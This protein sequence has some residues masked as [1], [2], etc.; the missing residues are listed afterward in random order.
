MKKILYIFLG[1]ILMVAGTV[2]AVTVFNSNQVGSSPVNGYILQTNGTVST[3]VPNVGNFAFPFTVFPNYSATTTVIGF[4]GLFST[5]S[6]TFS[7]PVLLSG[8]SVG[9]L[10]VGSN[11]LLYS[12]AT[13]TFSGGLTYSN[14]NVTCTGC[15]AVGNADLIY[16][17]LSNTA[18]YTASSSLTD[19]KSF[20]FRNGFVSNASSTLSAS[21]YFPYLTS[22]FGGIG[23][24][25]RLYSFATSTIKTSQL[26][27]D[28]AFIASVFADVPLSG[29]GTSA[30]HL[31]IPKATASV[32]GY[33]AQADFSKFNSA[34]T[35]FTTPIIYTLA[36]NAV[37]CQVASALLSGCI[38]AASFSQALSAT[39]TFSAPL[40]YTLGTNV[41]TC[42]TCT[43][44]G[45]ASGDPFTHA[46][47]FQSATSSLF[48]F[49]TTTSQI[50]QLT[51]GSSTV[52]Q[53]SLSDSAGIAQWV[54]RNAGGNLYL[55]TTTPQGLATSS[56]SA[57][58][59]LNNG[60]VGIGTT[61]PNAVNANGH[62]V[63]SGTE[64][65]DINCFTTTV[66]TT[67][68]CIFNAYADTGRIFMGQHGSAQN[69]TQYGQVVGGFGEVGMV[70]MTGG[71]ANGLL[72]GARNLSL[73]VIIGNNSTEKW[74][75]S[76]NG[77]I[78]IG[79]TTPFVQYTETIASSTQPQLSLSAGSNFPQLVLRNDGTNFYL[80]TTTVAGNAT[81]SISALEIAL[82]G[83]GTTTIRGLNI[84]GQA[85]S[86]SNVG[87]NI[88]TGCYA[89]SNT[90]LS[91][92]GSGLSSYDAWTHST[93][94]LNNSATTSKIGIGTTTPYYSLTI[95]STTGPQLSLSDGTA[96]IAQWVF[97]N[98]GGSL[99]ISTTT[100]A[101]TSTTT[102]P[103]IAFTGSQ[104]LIPDGT[105]A[106]PS[107]SF[108]DDPNNGIGSPAN[109]IFAIYTNGLERFRADDG[110]G[111]SAFG[112]TTPALGILTLASSTGSQ[113]VLSDGSAGDA[114]WT[115]R[116]A[117]G[118]F[119]LSTTTVA[120]TATTSPSAF[121]I[122]GTGVGVFLGATTSNSATTGVSIAGTSYWTG[123]SA[124]AGTQTGSLCL[125]A[126]NEVIN[127]SGVCI[128]S[129]KRAKNIVGKFTNAL[130]EISNLQ[131][132]IYFYKPEFNG[133]LQSNY[134]FSREQLGFTAQA[135]AKVDGKLVKVY[136]EDGTN[137]VFSY[138]K[139][140]PAEPDVYALV[141]LAL[142][143]VNELT[144]KGVK[145]AKDRWP[146]ILIAVQFL[147]FASYVVYN[148]K[149]RK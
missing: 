17:T 66:T 48:A 65:Q 106:A 37:T 59:I 15:G 131:P 35:T 49:G 70:N 57:L 85:T 109:D 31:T 3:W 58:T 126:T 8:L 125:S 14:G 148:E 10:N 72:I 86:T 108:L 93:I 56:P 83:F 9:Q 67:S 80:S 123:L 144:T 97:R 79:T 143:G 41:V 63:I 52:P 147:L 50:F 103:A 128:V 116:N 140:E 95:A 74:R 134:N 101:G 127:D 102:I 132:I 135:L 71:T 117:G 110:T 138:K 23:S 104:I 112:T 28:A 81:T 136:T 137:P 118:N 42:P 84:N 94:F 47:L 1:M 62:L 19:N 73:P 5:A 130:D 34:T 146:Y 26:T 38:S 43:I 27:N 36:T 16:L 2:S 20:Y 53:L 142:G 46:Y 129:D 120:G 30:S 21:T 107:I 113:L 7:G 39:T 77:A 82:G 69:T 76:G 145:T 141:T 13:T 24:D 61:T 124:S 60:N 18:F 98:A 149:K 87:M 99:F 75:V 100:V 22:G 92:S 55:A 12:G 32:D 33:L 51:I 54:F 133:N 44:I 40:V 96:G 139:G 68:D 89:I 115:M 11:G 25:G 6:S 64:S 122:N 90:C 105:G 45:S 111:R 121:T 119:Y 4:N 78:G 29:N 91:T 88:S 114:Q